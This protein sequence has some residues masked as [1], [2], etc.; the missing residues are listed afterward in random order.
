MNSMLTDQ[1]MAATTERIAGG[2]TAPASAR[3]LLSDV[4]SASTQGDAL[5]DV[6]LLTTELVTN[7][8]RHADVDETGS[9]E[10][11]V[12]AQPHSVR[13][14]VSDPGGPTSPAVQDLDPTSP[15]GMGLFLVDQI[16]S[17]W[18]SERAPGG[19]TRVWFEVPR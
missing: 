18:A 16:A 8:V 4:L 12:L 17:R 9:V 15:G 7:A 11:T 5:H 19:G 14:A 10:L 3:E 2:P 1:D 6:L 13:V